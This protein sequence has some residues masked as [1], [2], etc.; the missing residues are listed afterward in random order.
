MCALDVTG[1]LDT[2]FSTTS[3]FLSCL[4]AGESDLFVGV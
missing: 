3:S 4:T 2:F 1:V